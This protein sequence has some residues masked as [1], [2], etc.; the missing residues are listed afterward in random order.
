M[1]YYK[2]IMVAAHIIFIKFFSH[3]FYPSLFLLFQEAKKRKYG[4][5][6]EPRVQCARLSKQKERRQKKNQPLFV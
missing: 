2:H 3:N 4:I 6:S 5:D 1:V